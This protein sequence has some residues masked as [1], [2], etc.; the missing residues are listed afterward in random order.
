[1]A[2][3]LQRMQRSFGGRRRYLQQLAHGRGTL[4]WHGFRH[5]VRPAIGNFV[6]QHRYMMR[7]E[8]HLHVM[9]CLLKLELLL[10]HLVG[11]LNR[12]H[13]VGVCGERAQ[14]ALRRA[15]PQLGIPQHLCGRAHLALQSNALTH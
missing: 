11:A 9:R 14:R 3:A 2:C 1:M 8:A 5:C 10:H 6:A 15:A 7:Q 4:D 12:A 13:Y